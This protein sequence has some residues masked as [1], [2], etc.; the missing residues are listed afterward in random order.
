[1]EGGVRWKNLPVAEVAESFPILT[2]RGIAL[3]DRGEFGHGRIDRD[4]W[5]VEAVEAGAVVFRTEVEGVIARSLSNEANLCEVG[6]AT[7]IRTSGDAEA[8][9][10][11]AKA[12]LIEDGLKLSK[13]GGEIALTF[14]K[15]QST[16]RKGD[17]GEGIQT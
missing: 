13:D 11:V 2:L 10:V 1:V 5:G 6:A 8:D 15:C 14:S 16:G 3:D 12:G 17:A 4:T 7:A 9:R